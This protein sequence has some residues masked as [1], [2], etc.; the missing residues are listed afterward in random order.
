M[1][2]TRKIL[3]GL[4]AGVAT[5]L[6]L[7][8]LVAPLQIVAEGFI[9]LLQMTVLPYVTVSI[10]SSLGAL[11]VAQAKALGFRGGAVLLGLWAIAFTA[12]LLF[13]IAFPQAETASFFST[14]LVE[15][16]RPFDFVGLYIPANPFHALANNVVPAVVLFS[17]ILGVALIGVEEK[18]ALLEVLGTTTRAIA[19]ATRAVVALT[20]Y[21]LFAIAAVAAGT[22]TFEQLQRIQVYLVTYVI[23]SLI[24]G[25]WVMPGVVSALTG[26]RVR[27]LFHRTRDSLIVAFVAA[28]LFIVLPGLIEACKELLVARGGAAT[29]E[30]AEGTHDDLMAGPDVIVPVSFNFPHTG[31]LLS[32][33]FIPFAAWYADAPLRLADY[34]QL[35][36]AGALS[37][38]GSLNSAIPF[39]LDLFHVPA[40]TFQ[41]FIATGVINSRFGTLLAAMHTIT[42]ALLGSAALTGGLQWNVRR[43]ARFALLTTVLVVG[44][45]LGL[46]VL[47]STVLRQDFAG[48]ELVYSMTS[49]SGLPA[50]RLMTTLPVATD[51]RDQD[52]LTAIHK[53]GV[54]RVAVL[55]DRMPFAFRNRE[56]LLVGMDV[57]LAQ[58]LAGDA[59]VGVEFYSVDSPAALRDLLSEGACDIAMS[60]VAVTAERAADHLFSQP[61]L[62]ETLAF[63][64][65]DH[66][67]DRFQTWSAIRELGAI[68]VGVPDLP[69]YRRAV[70]TR[71]PQVEIVPLRQFEDLFKSEDDLMAYVLPAERGSVLTLLHPS[72]SV[73]VP[74][75]NTIKLPVAYPIAR[76]DE[77]WANYV[78]TWLELKRRDGTIDALYRHWILG[79]RAQPSP[80]RWS[81]VR[82]VFGW[83]K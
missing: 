13:P 65:K 67:R 34:P 60:G 63:V 78:N 81:M 75:P 6:L 55:P 29:G 3:I 47:F 31:K 17:V 42:V 69:T 1:T 24:V 33:S 39:L 25:L 9:R 70:S 14:T 80:P 76:G 32:L 16:R 82:N 74:Q 30:R 5:G 51:A 56:G 15:T 53:R 40:D 61:Y 20:P 23:V 8:E 43:L 62:D 4:G 22:L 54:L 19:R 52:V 27:D 37:F 83:V 77:R 10:I 48:E 57:E 64:T 49:L 18:A 72:Y 12:T 66:L 35:F 68:R 7:G 41:L 46:R 50:P 71:A 28:D 36:A 79:Q 73:V 45:L 11:S 38:F 58:T 26:I 21:G 2:F 59:G 44:T